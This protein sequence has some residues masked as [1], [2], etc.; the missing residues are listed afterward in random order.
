MANVPKTT[1]RMT[2][3]ESSGPTS[4]DLAALIVDALLRASII[5]SQDIER[6]LEVVVEELEVRKSLGDY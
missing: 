2:R 1:S 3:A 5:R 4:K 6:A